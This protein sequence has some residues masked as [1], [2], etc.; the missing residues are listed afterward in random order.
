M[1]HDFDY[2]KYPT[3]QDHVLQRRG[4]SGSGDD[5]GRSS[6]RSAARPFCTK[7]PRE[8][9]MEKAILAADEPTGCVRAGAHIR[10][11]LC[12]RTSWTPSERFLTQIRRNFEPRR[13]NPRT[14]VP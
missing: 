14:P 13:R 12:P 1:R 7:I 10:T 6:R 9:A 4:P 3:E 5:P 2:E 8:T 11:S